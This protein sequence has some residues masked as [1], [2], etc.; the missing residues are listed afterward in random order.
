MHI[1]RRLGAQG[2][3]IKSVWNVPKLKKPHYNVYI[4]M[5]VYTYTYACMYVYTY[6]VCMYMYMYVYTVYLLLKVK[7]MMYM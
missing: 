3:E 1:E 2:E 4:C 6:S 7:Y 5:Y